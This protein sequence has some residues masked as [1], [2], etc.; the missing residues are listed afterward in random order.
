MAKHSASPNGDDLRLGDTSPEADLVL[1]VDALE[2]TAPIAKMSRPKRLA[3]SGLSA[4]TASTLM[5]ERWDSTAAYLTLVTVWLCWVGRSIVHLLKG[6]FNTRSA[7]GDT[8]LRK[9]LIAECILSTAS[10]SALCCTDV[11]LHNRPCH[12]AVLVLTACSMWL[13]GR[14]EALKI[15]AEQR[16]TPG[17]F[18]TGTAWLGSRIFDR[19]VV[20]KQWL[21]LF[22]R[23]YLVTMMTFVLVFEAM[24]G[25]ISP[26]QLISRYIFHDGQSESGGTKPA[27]QPSASHSPSASGSAS[28]SA[29]SSTSSPSAQSTA[30]A[31]TVSPSPH[32][33]TYEELCVTPGKGPQPGTGASPWAQSN[34][35][36]FVLGHGGK[37]GDVTGCLQRSLAATSN[38][39]YAIGLDPDTADIKTVI[40][41]TKDCMTYMFSGAAVRPIL[42]LLESGH[43]IC[44]EARH[45][46]AVGDAQLIQTQE[47]TFALIRPTGATSFTVL[48]PAET[49]AWAR[50]E[51][52]TH[53]WLWPNRTRSGVQLNDQDGPLDYYISP[54]AGRA[55]LTRNGKK[56]YYRS[57]S[58]T[59]W[60]AVKR[61]AESA[62]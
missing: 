11:L 58:V 42:D 6:D 15:A 38:T 5:L 55:V 16:N 19:N 4:T 56:T 14:A 51:Q 39:Y 21:P 35:Y 49:A 29:G 60:N 3:F 33:K 41:T 62:S 47:G 61:F 13:I 23:S 44:P 20:V 9:W 24:N 17:R 46:V 50:A 53:R 43:M 18:V 54:S 34:L 45:A 25:Y 2:I 52:E 27:G 59:R 28:P 36:D 7:D 57:G 40:T 26:R 32:Q 12:A 22:G 37:G 48:T 30:P 8:P 10:I 1:T 31:P